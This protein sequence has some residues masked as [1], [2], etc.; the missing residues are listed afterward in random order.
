MLLCRTFN[1]KTD[2]FLPS[3]G[4]FDRLIVTRGERTAARGCSSLHSHGS[5]CVPVRVCA[6]C[7]P[8]C[9]TIAFSFRALP[10]W[11]LPAHRC[12][13][14]PAWLTDCWADRGRSDPSRPVPRSL[15]GTH[16]QTDR[17]DQAVSWWTFLPRRGIRN[18]AK[19][20]RR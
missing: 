11:W 16:W 14:L 1:V 19:C 4:A 2:V 17:E 6:R 9:Y 13:P 7:G 8:F 20:G 15:S 5:V 12:S 18:S 10:A 3:R